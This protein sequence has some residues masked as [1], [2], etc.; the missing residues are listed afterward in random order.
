MKAYV[1]IY[2]LSLVPCHCYSSLVPRPYTSYLQPSS[3]A[4][5]FKIDD[6]T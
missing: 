5:Y 1:T 3:G 2:Y 4:T 6:N